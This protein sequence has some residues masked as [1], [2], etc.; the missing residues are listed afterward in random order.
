MIL[1]TYFA[2]FCKIFC[3]MK[4]QQEDL[5]QA[6]RNVAESHDLQKHVGVPG[7]VAMP[8]IA[9]EVNVATYKSYTYVYV[10]Y[11]IKRKDIIIIHWC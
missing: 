8:G 6:Q 10:L 11:N 7:S 4:F 3:H 5:H 9:D 1:Q 2:R